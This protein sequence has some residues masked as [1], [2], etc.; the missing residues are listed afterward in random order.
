MP[1]YDYIKIKRRL[2]GVNGKMEVWKCGK[3]QSWYKNS[4]N[5]HYTLNIWMKLTIFEPGIFCYEG[6][7]SYSYSR[8]KISY[9]LLQEWFCYLYPTWN[10]D[11]EWKWVISNLIWHK[12]YHQGYFIPSEEVITLS[13]P[14]IL[15]IYSFP[16][17]YV[18]LFLLIHDPLLFSIPRFVF[19]AVTLI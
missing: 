12:K 7:C 10:V 15:H 13:R 3:K 9:C 14:F 8:T 1:F 6:I 19:N 11:W 16:I 5:S 17:I 18:F 2:Y 4:P